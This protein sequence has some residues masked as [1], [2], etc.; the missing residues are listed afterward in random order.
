MF[1]GLSKHYETLKAL[2]LDFPLKSINSQKINKELKQKAKNLESLK[3][4]NYI[5][6]DQQSTF[7]KGLLD[8]G[9]LPSLKAF[10]FGG[11]QNDRS[12]MFG[13]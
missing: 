4:G 9:K 3:L 12:G 8:L 13:C 6:E 10:K 11:F 5:T 2:F 1:K 7:Q